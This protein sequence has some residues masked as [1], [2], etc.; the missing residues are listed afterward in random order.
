ME[1]KNNI[2]S[3]LSPKKIAILLIVLILIIII[4]ISCFG[5]ND[6]TE[7]NTISPEVFKEATVV[8][9]VDGDTIWIDG[10]DGNDKVRLIGIDAP[11]IDYY[12]SEKTDG[13]LSSEFLESI[14]TEGQTVYLQADVSDNDSYNRLLRYI[15]TE[16]PTDKDNEDEI[17]TKMLNAII[18]INGYAKAIAFEPDTR[19]SDLF[20]KLQTQAEQEKSGLWSD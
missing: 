20:E 4:A 2:Y 12:S 7:T 5:K 9:I 13:D 10:E 6:K 15:W 8:K 11:E 18:L 16:I 1:K 14:L 19:Y 17:S 3:S